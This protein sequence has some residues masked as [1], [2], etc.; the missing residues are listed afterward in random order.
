MHIFLP[1]LHPLASDGIVVLFC[2]MLD[3]FKGVKKKARVKTV[4]CYFTRTV[5]HDTIYMSTYSCAYASMCLRLFAY[6]FDYCFYHSPTSLSA[7]R[8]LESIDESII[9]IF[10]HLKRSSR[11]CWSTGKASSGRALGWKKSSSLTS[12]AWAERVCSVLSRMVP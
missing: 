9:I 8:Y 2:Q 10:D 11:I 12:S 5:Y 6:L 7:S 3:D 4:F 1:Y